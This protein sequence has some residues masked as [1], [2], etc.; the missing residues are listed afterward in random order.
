VFQGNLQLA[1]LAFD[2]GT[3]AHSSVSQLAVQSLVG[4]AS[5]AVTTNSSSTG[6]RVFIV[7]IEPILDGRLGAPGGLRVALY[8]K[9]GSSYQISYK[10]NLMGGDWVVAFRTPQTNIT[11]ELSIAATLPKA[12]YRAEEFTPDPPLI[13]LRGLPGPNAPLLVY[14]RKGSNYILESSAVL[15]ASNGWGSLSGFAFSNAFGFF[16][17]P[18]NTNSAAY[19]RIR[20]P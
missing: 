5:G 2:T 14:G 19:F 18:G 12:Y 11:Q 4:V 7:G 16:G 13:E 10:T 1:R 8:G 3:N 17:I 20:R 15:G 6:G 9:A